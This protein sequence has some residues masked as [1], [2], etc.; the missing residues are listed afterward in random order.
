MNYYLHSTS[1]LF[2]VRTEK[3]LCSYYNIKYKKYN[4]Q[5]IN[6]FKVINSFAIS[7]HENHLIYQT[8]IIPLILVEFS[9]NQSSSTISQRHFRL[10]RVWCRLM[11]LSGH[12]VQ[13]IRLLE[14]CKSRNFASI[15]LSAFLYITS[16]F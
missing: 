14:R 1:V 11:A 4:A 3:I 7:G 12:L 6:N 5:T 13:S 10:F 2:L 15:S 8:W 16:Y 9:E